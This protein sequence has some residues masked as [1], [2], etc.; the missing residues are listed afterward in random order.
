MWRGA[1]ST[2]LKRL[3]L[4]SA[5]APLAGCPMFGCPDLGT[6]EVD[7]ALDGG[8]QGDGAVGEGGA[9]DPLQCDQLCRDTGYFGS[10]KCSLTGPDHVH[11][12]IHEQCIGGRRAD[13]AP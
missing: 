13:P 7:V 4:A 6:H 2:Y 9:L 8:Y 12:S 1:L 11:C 3:V 5:L 10:V